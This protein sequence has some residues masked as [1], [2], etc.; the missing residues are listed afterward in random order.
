M[1]PAPSELLPQAPCL[2]SLGS[3]LPHLPP[4]LIAVCGA[5]SC[6]PSFGQVKS[7]DRIL[8]R[9]GREGGAEAGSPGFSRLFA[10]QC[11]RTSLALEVT[12]VGGLA[13]PPP[14]PSAPPRQVSH[15]SSPSVPAA[16]LCDGLSLCAPI[17]PSVAQQP[18]APGRVEGVQDT[19]PPTRGRTER[20]HHRL[21]GTGTRRPGELRQRHL[22]VVLTVAADVNVLSLRHPND[23]VDA[24]LQVAPSAGP[25]SASGSSQPIRGPRPEPDSPSAQHPER[26]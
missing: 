26:L 14:P 2:Q 7:R 18:R 5:P 1:L 9:G 21:L 6:R 3:P 23:G 20:A 8:W 25:P 12:P 4:L 17:S 16:S 22:R 19:P 24:D 10:S 13:P 11:V 15:P